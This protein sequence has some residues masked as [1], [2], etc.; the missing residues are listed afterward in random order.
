MLSFLDVIRI[1]W[2]IHPILLPCG[3]QFR[4]KTFNFTVELLDVGS[5]GHFSVD[6][7]TIPDVFGP[8]CVIQGG[9]RFLCTVHCGGNGGDD[10]GFGFAAQGVS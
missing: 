8:M 2:N 5:F 3:M 9:Q 1:T 6:F 4:F 7:W 10:A